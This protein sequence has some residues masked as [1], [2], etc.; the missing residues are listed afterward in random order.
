MPIRAPTHHPYARAPRIVRGV[1]TQPRVRGLTRK[2]RNARLARRNPLCV[3]CSEAGRTE[4][5]TEW[6]HVV[7][8]VDGGLDHESNLQGLCHPCHA[9]K[10]AAE[11]RGR[12]G[13]AGTVK[14]L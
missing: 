4:A 12:R 5:A 8:L 3:M 1:S 13:R 2:N 10:T 11:Q 6:D 7:P 9:N 14:G